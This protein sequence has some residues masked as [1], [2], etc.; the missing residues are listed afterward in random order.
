MIWLYRLLFPPVM[1]LAAPYYLL[2]MR[3]RG[4][5]RSNFSQRFGATPAL[6]AKRPGVKRVWLQAVSVGEMLA[7]APLLEGLR[8]DPAVEVYLT[9]TTS[10][11]YALA[12]ERYAALTAGIAYFPIDGWPFSRRAWSRIAP[13]LVILTEGERWPEH[14]HQAATRGIPVL[15]V[16]A[17][18][19]DR[20]FNRMRRFRGLVGALLGGVTRVLAGSALDAE[21]FRSLGF[22]AERIITTGNI[23]LDVTIPAISEAEKSA[24][25]QELGLGDAPV[26]LGSSTWPD[27][28][29]AMLKV[30]QALRSEGQAVRLLLVP[31]H[32]ERRAEIETLLKGAG[33][34]YHFRSRGAASAPVEVAVGDTTGELR[35]L[36]QL[37]QVVFVGKSLPP[38]HEGQTPVEAAVLGKPVVFGPALSNFRAIARELRETGAARSVANAGELAAVVKEL[39][40]DAAARAR[41]AA[42]A[43]A[44]HLANQGAVARTLAV[45]RA[46]LAG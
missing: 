21:R 38:H 7:I 44:W 30:Y 43:Q 4:G 17:R 10:T 22:P 3:R 14:I 5:Y 33:V 27:E 6:P 2:R 16:N 31:R 19:S 24:L 8:A 42:A 11:G 41:M 35:R 26:L 36:T 20:S 23:K 45:I 9:T 37:A 28:E 46:E 15:A 25:R 29:A 39:W 12:C 32:A 18:L 1:V 13:D 34:S 40:T